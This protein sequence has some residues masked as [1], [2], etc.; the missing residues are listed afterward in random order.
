MNDVYNISKDEADSLGLQH[1]NTGANNDD[2]DIGGPSMGGGG[3][4][5][6]GSRNKVTGAPLPGLGERPVGELG[7][8]SSSSFRDRGGDSSGGRYSSNDNTRNTSRYSSDRDG[9][10]SRYSSNDSNGRYSSNDTNGGGGGGGR[11]SRDRNG[12][13]GGDR[14]NNS[15]RRQHNGPRDRY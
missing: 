11:Y 8:F 9:G 5:S 7:D 4:Y 13:S 10:G 12:G 3:G 1:T 15:D 14:R 6:S 2:D